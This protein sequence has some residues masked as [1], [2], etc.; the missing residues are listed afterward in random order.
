MRLVQENPVTIP[1]KLCG[2]FHAHGLEV[3]GPDT[4]I[5]LVMFGQHC[6]SGS[7]RV[8]VLYT[9]DGEPVGYSWWLISNDMMFANKPRADEMAI[10]VKPEYRGRWAIR[11]IKFSELALIKEGIKRLV[12]CAKKGSSLEHVFEK[13]GYGKPEVLRFKEV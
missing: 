2:L 10:Y 9:D 12:R 8:F 4:N 13:L 7:S 1:G 5:N 3:Y 11:L 6:L